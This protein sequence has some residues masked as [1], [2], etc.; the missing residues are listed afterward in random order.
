MVKIYDLNGNVAGEIKLPHVFNSAYRPDIIQRA[1]LA[2]QS[3]N[4]QPYGINPL[5]GKR[6]SAHY[7]GVKATYASMK[8]RE[9]ARMAR[10]HGKG[11]PGLILTAR[12][13]PQA[14]KGR[15][16]HPPKIEKIWS[17]KIND[18]E[19]KLAIRS[20][21]AATVMKDLVIARGHKVSDFELP[22]IISDDLEKIT[23]TKEVEK[24]IG[25]L[26]L[27]SEIERA[28]NKT[29]RA[30]RGKMRGRRYKKKKSMLFIVSKDQGLLKS[31]KNFA[32]CDVSLVENLNAE[33]LAPGTH[34]G[35]LT[36]WSE[37]AVK[38]LG[39]IFG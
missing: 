8:N 30:G 10:I 17:Q 12:F 5:A 9:I 35:R 11:S 18:K 20:A 31:A 15:E 38:K 4:R 2:I 7:H 28:K 39:D 24:L 37:S 36:I 1:V 16:S 33:I 32:G 3:H 23:K 27:D 6:T 29:V 19:R 25:N 22:I 14:R 34:A 13:V 26:K 21:I